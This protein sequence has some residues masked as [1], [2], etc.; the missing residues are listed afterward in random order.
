VSELVQSAD[1]MM[2]SVFENCCWDKELLERVQHR[3]TRMIKE[4]C[5][6]DYLDRLKELN[7]WTLEERRN[8]AF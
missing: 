8:R 2:A 7:L 4:V 3:F 6:K 1:E 5:D